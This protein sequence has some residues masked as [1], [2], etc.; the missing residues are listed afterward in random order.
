MFDRHANDPPI[1]SVHRTPATKVLLALLL[2]LPLFS[3]ARQLPTSPT[4]GVVG[5][6][7]LATNSLDDIGSQ[8]VVT[9]GPD[10]DPEAIGTELQATLIDIEEGVALYQRTDPTD[11]TLGTRHAPHATSFEPNVLV[12]TAE[13]RQKSWAFDDGFGCLQT[14]IDQVAARRLGVAEAH[15]QSTGAGVRVAIL[16]TGIDPNHPL[17]ANRIVGGY[18]FVDH[19]NDPTDEPT[20]TDANDDGVVDGSY[21][22]GTHVAGIVAMT[23]P[24]AQL[25]IVRVLDAEGRGDVQ[26]IAAGIR[27]AVRNGANVINMSLGMT[28]LSPA[29]AVAI[30][31]AATH[32]VVCVASAGNDGSD[33]P[34][35][36]PASNPLVIGVAACDADCRPAD[37]TSYGD[38]VALAAPGV[39]VRSA[40]PGNAYRLWSGTSMSAPFVS[41]TAA[42]LLSTHP[43]WGMQQVL[44]RLQ[45]TAHAVVDASP[46]Q[47]GRVGHGALDVS[48]ALALDATTTAVTDKALGQGRKHGLPR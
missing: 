5:H 23:A 33:T 42:L 14:T 16:D 32:G 31:E 9:L 12:L 29:V 34:V 15:D 2:A 18:D 6:A 30:G 41:G 47:A 17:F 13:A 19:D 8:V 46:Q 28:T 25:L 37:F 43:R 1:A 21:G 44:N 26:R 40:Y 39:A 22:H 10:S 4:H 3:C 48:G 38:Y 7:T 11:V 27:W 20:G 36:Y 35:E 24:D 45:Y